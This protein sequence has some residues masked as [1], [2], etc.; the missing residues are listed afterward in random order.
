VGIL[1]KLGIATF[2]AANTRILFR[3]FTSI[4]IITIL[5]SLYSKYEALLLVTAP[6]KLF[7]PLYLFTTIVFLL[8][9]WTLLSFK[10]FASFKEAKNKLEILNSYQDMPDEYHMINDISKFPKLRT[11]KDDI[12]K[13]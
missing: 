10:W 9:I 3:L 6:E 13:K 8:I 4:I 1:T 5:N 11:K 2:I 7:V 12:L